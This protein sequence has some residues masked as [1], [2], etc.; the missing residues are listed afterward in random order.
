MFMASRQRKTGLLMVLLGLTMTMTAMAAEGQP[1]RFSQEGLKGWQEKSF[2]GETRYTLTTDSGKQVLQAQSHA[3]ASGLF[4]EQ[5]V[6]LVKTPYLNWSWKVANVLSGIDEHSKAG[7][8]FAARVYLVVSG[9]ALFWKTRSLVYVWSSNQPVN[10]AWE[11]PFTGNARHIAVRSGAA[12]V[13]QWLSEKRNIRED[14]KRVFGEDIET[15]DAVAI[16][17]DTDNSGQ[18]AT[19]WYGDIYFSA[20]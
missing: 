11:N 4:Y 12:E 3:T 14:F 2:Q 20:D 17:T 16:M 13:G 5:A 10:S 15:I 8:D 6:N 1:G 7:D 18:S 9:G 19:A